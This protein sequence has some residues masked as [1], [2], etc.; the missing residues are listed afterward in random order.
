MVGAELQQD[1]HGMT[2]AAL[3]DGSRLRR[4][5]ARLVTEIL[6][7]APTVAMLLVV[8]AWN[9]SATVG[10]GLKWAIPAIFFSSFVPILYIV[11]GVRRRQLT[12]HHVRL[13][14]QRGK[15]LLVAIA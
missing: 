3:G 13:R 6:A 1:S 15:P 11:R 4:R 9:G 10:E 7:P 12:D 14:K 5:M 2:P 8:V